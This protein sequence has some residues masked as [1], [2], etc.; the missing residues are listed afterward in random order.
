M[1]LHKIGLLLLSLFI[2]CS[3]FACLDGETFKNVTSSGN[4]PTDKDLWVQR[5]EFTQNGSHLEEAEK[6][7]GY[8][9]Q[10]L[11][12][13]YGENDSLTYEGLTLLLK[14]LGLGKVQVIQIQHRDLGHDHVS[15]LDIL[16]VQ[17][18]KHKHVHSTSEHL[19]APSGPEESKNINSQNGSSGIS[20]KSNGA[21]HITKDPGPGKS[22]VHDGKRVTVNHLQEWPPRD[23]LQRLLHL[24]HS[25]NTHLHE[26]CLN[27]TQLLLNFGLSRVSEITPQ[28]F[29][30]L[31]PALLYQIDSRVCIHHS[32]QLS[33]QST[34]SQQPL[35]KVL[36]WGALAVTVISAPSL[37]AVAF[38]PLLRRPVFRYLLRFLVALA[39]GT[40]CGDAL[41][42]LLPHAQEDPSEDTHHNGSHSLDPVLKGLCVLGGIYFLFLIENLMGLLRHRRKRKKKRL[43]NKKT[44]QDEGCTTVLWD[45]GHPV[46]PEFCDA[47]RTGDICEQSPEA[48]AEVP[49]SRGQTAHSHHGHSHSG[50]SIA[51]YVWMV[52]LGDGIHNFTDGLAIGAAF[53]ASFS[54]GLSTTVA[55]FCH[56]LPHELGDFA[57]LLQTGVQMRRVLFFSL[58]SA[59]L[60]YLGMVVGSVVSQ[61]SNQVTPW[62]FAATAGIFL[63]VALVD[64]LPQMLHRE[65]TDLGQGKDCVL[66][67]IGFLLGC[68]IMLCIALFQDQMVFLHL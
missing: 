39:V 29:T 42:H 38:V 54:G 47:R 27:V 21:H 34:N 46:G 65:P 57:V 64:M 28:Q 7:Q 59:I 37:L 5:T 62:I 14:N 25:E 15:H 35:L 55:V 30:L 9:L 33:P 12:N 63:Y 41:L 43:Q 6:E 2:S 68:G 23:I 20:Q 50:G 4:Q 49:E 32:D 10:Q 44:T 1:Q 13:L 26:D 52:L 22:T 58:I 31:C 67:S 8:Y 40:L 3:L 18:N 56:E 16:D 66:H 61:S 36:G 19:P 51:E 17:E 48:Q 11:F 53:S 24:H 45:L 60:S